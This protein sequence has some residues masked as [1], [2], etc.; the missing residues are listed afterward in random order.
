ML[1]WFK[2]ACIW[3]PMRL[4]LLKWLLAT[5]MS[6][7]NCLLFSVFFG[8]SFFISQPGLMIFALSF[9]LLQKKKK[10]KRQ[11]VFHAMNSRR[12]AIRYSNCLGGSLVSCGGRLHSWNRAT[13]WKHDSLTT[14]SLC[15]ECCSINTN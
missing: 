4:N 10:K 7:M 6:S 1:L 8:F 9:E 13:D 15:V 5:P 2:F 11:Q 12:L 3:L 14:C